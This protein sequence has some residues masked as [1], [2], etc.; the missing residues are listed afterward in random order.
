MKILLADD[1]IT[2]QKLGTK[3]LSDAGYE[4]ISVSNG[5]AAMKKIAAE[6]PHLLILDVFM[7]GYTGL[8]VCEKVKNSPDTSRV[9]VLLTVTNMEPFNPGEG[10]RVRA[11]GVMIKPFEASD[12]LAVVQKLEKK[13]GMAPAKGKGSGLDMDRAPEVKLSPPLNAEFKDASYEEWKAPQPPA[14]PMDEEEEPVTPKKQAPRIEMP[15]DVASS[16]VFGTDEIE[17][18]HVPKTAE[19][20]PSQPQEFAVQQEPAPPDALPS[21]SGFVNEEVVH[22]AAIP[23]HPDTGPD[24][25]GWEHNSEPQVG[26]IDV[27]PAPELEVTAQESPAELNVAAGPALVVNASAGVEGQMPNANCQVPT[28]KCQPVM[29]APEPAVGEAPITR[30]TGVV[31]TTPRPEP[32]LQQVGNN[33]GSYSFE[34]E[35]RRA[36]AAGM[37][38]AAAAA[39]PDVEAAAVEAPHAQSEP[40]AEVVAGSE[41]GIT[42]TEPVPEDLTEKLAAEFVAEIEEADEPE[43]HVEIVNG[44]ELVSDDSSAAAITANDTASI[45]AADDERISQAVERVL[46]RY[47]PQLI[48]DIVRELK[49]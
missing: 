45:Q 17:S 10:N 46:N 2:A 34:L 41:P 21:V 22:A 15:H 27:A 6:K 23:R 25:L 8:E 4:V 20:A 44:A 24:A 19:P 5:A 47:R 39:A 49:G 26:Q 29:L 9:P 7:P 40:F 43:G 18:P 48:A 42:S 37:S 30:D 3:I 38:S 31:D 13:L 28:A 33:S 32:E 16:P 35:M 12:L 11:D 36:F 1:N 14:P